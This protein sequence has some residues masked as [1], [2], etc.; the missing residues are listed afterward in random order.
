MECDPRARARVELATF[1]KGKGI[2]CVSQLE[3]RRGT[4]DVMQPRSSVSAPQR[5]G[6]ESLIEETELVLSSGGEKAQQRGASP[7]VKERPLGAFVQKKNLGQGIGMGPNQELSFGLSCLTKAQGALVGS[8]RRLEGA[9]QTLPSVERVSQRMEGTPHELQ[10]SVEDV[11]LV[12]EQ[13]NPQVFD[14]LG[15]V[16]MNDVLLEE[17]ARF[18]GQIPSVLSL[19]G[20]GFFSS[21]PSLPSDGKGLGPLVCWEDSRSFS[22]DGDAVEP[23]PLHIVQLDGSEV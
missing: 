6:S 22:M 10:I 1:S 16:I 12:L 17:A 3:Q 9:A 23:G 15:A 14:A 13:R 19:R 21:T 2:D 20:V 18:T 4:G 7:R 5:D 8:F 11:R